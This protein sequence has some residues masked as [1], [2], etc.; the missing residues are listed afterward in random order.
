MGEMDYS[1]Q[2]HDGV[3]EWKKQ[4]TQLLKKGYVTIITI[5]MRTVDR[6]K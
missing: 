5:S 4:S 6:T 2:A 3:M 1:S